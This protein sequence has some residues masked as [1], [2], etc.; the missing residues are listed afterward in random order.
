[1]CGFRAALVLALGSLIPGLTTST[2]A[3]DRQTS[4]IR[5]TDLTN[6]DVLEMLQAGLPQEVVIAKINS[7]PCD[8]D[9][10][11]IGLKE[12][13]AAHVPKK[14]MVAMI[15]APAAAS[16]ACAHA[17]ARTPAN[18]ISG[19]IQNISPDEMWKRVTQCIFPA[20]PQLAFNSH[21]TGTVDIGL[22]ISPDGDVGKGKH[23]RVLDGPAPLTQ[24]A[25]EA[26]RQW[27]FQPNAV[28]GEMTWTRVR[29]LVRFNDDGTTLVDLAPAILAD[30][31]G[32]PG[33]PRSAATAL[34]RPAI[35]PEC[36]PDKNH[37]PRPIFTPE[38]DY[39]ETGR[40]ARKQGEV[41]L[42]LIVGTDG[43]PRDIKVLGSTG[44]D[45]EQ[46]AIE[47]VQQWR[48]EPALKDGEAVE[49]P[50]QVRVRFRIR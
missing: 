35:A 39:P 21:I 10:S 26:I 34:P 3:Q 7:S 2:A 1:M 18:K 44:K 50:I 45:F 29:A 20:Y 11:P 22:G 12:L 46:K 19:R 42:A 4:E 25:M 41:W 30:D 28:Q 49:K 23:S 43:L 14:V 36:K 9:T 47:T 48:F 32:D 38:A 33:T 31:F 24:A 6:E 17:G 27:K 40:R 15:Q 13:K 5:N 8:L 37:G 16:P